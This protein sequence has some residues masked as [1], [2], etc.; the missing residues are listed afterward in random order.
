MISDLLVHFE[1]IYGVITSYR[2]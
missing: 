1:K 2:L